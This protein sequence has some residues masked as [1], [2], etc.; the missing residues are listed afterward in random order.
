MDHSPRFGPRGAVLSL[1]AA[2]AVLAWSQPCLAGADDLVALVRAG[3]RAARESI[4]TLSAK[5]TVEYAFPERQVIRSGHYWRSLDTARVH[6]DLGF[7]A[8]HYLLRG[9]ELRQ[10][11]VGRRPDGRSQY[12]AVRKPRGSLMC[13]CD[14]WNQM[15]IDMLGPGDSR[16]YDLDA[17][18]DLSKQSPRAVRDKCDGRECVRLTLRFDT[19]FGEDTLTLWHDVGCNYLIRKKKEEVGTGSVVMQ[20][21]EFTEAEGGVFVPTKLRRESLRNGKLASADE[22]TLS[23]VAINRPIP[24]DV[25]PLPAIPSGT[26]LMDQVQGGRYP[27]D[28]NWNRIGPAEPLQLV[29]GPGAGTAGSVDYRSPTAAEPASAVRWLAPISLGLVVTAGA[30]VC[31]RRWRAR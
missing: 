2:F 17:Y 15:L 14:A 6:E 20:I 22:V 4:R 12:A 16:Q 1:T 29:T 26:V 23:E 10:V 13:L 28:S 25:F 5:V 7:R 30:G 18:L 11:G 8:E 21:L 31:Y 24:E 19:G 3:H 27:I 9:S